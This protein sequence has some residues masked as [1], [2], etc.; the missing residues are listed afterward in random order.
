MWA[1]GR[2]QGA[3]EATAV[4]VYLCTHTA[5]PAAVTATI[6]FTMW[7]GM[8]EGSPLGEGATNGNTSP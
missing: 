1:L 6:P 4:L 2:G 7:L 8:W 5:F 3:V